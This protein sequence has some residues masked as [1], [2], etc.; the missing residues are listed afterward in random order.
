VNVLQRGG[1][2]RDLTIKL[3]LSGVTGGW[4]AT[5]TA[6]MYTWSPSLFYGSVIFFVL[7]VFAYWQKNADYRR[8]AYPPV[9]LPVPP[10]GC[11]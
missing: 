3:E 9:C 1:Q 6:A 8:H 5:D 10:D 4:R 11:T 2:A 7:V